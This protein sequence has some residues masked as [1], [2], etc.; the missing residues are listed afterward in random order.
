MAFE[1]AVELEPDALWPSK[2]STAG[3]GSHSRRMVFE[4]L[5]SVTSTPSS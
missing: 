5:I 4:R 1:A 2:S 3:A